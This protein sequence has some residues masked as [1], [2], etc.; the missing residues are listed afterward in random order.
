MND[1]YDAGS[2]EG[3]EVVVDVEDAPAS[4]YAGEFGIFNDGFDKPCEEVTFGKEIGVED[5]QIIPGRFRQHGVEVAGLVTD[6]FTAPTD[7]DAGIFF[8][9]YIDRF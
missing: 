3:V 5:K 6:V 1:I 7:F 8:G 4:L 2:H 9:K